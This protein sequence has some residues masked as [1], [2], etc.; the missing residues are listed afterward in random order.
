MKNRR[1]KWWL[2]LMC[3]GALSTAPAMHGHGAAAPVLSAVTPNPLS[4]GTITVTV[5]GTGFVSGALLYDSY[6]SNSNIQYTPT[7][8]T[9]TSGTASIYQGPAST[10]TFSVK[11]PGSDYSNT[12]TVPVTSGSSGSGDGGNQTYMLTVNNGTGSGS[13][14]AG[15]SVTITANQAPTGEA[16]QAWTGHG[17]ER[18]ECFNHAHDAGSERH[19]NGE[20]L[21]A[22]ADSFSGDH[23]SAAVDHAAGSAAAAVVGRAE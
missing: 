6:G 9:S 1:G 23:A 2:W 19:G 18:A 3:A 8:V 11:N 4:V 15:S 17:R 16:F 12:I 22:C 13:Y 14:T 21:H 7:S 20:L 5:T 10:S